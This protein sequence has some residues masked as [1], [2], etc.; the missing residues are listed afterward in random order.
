MLRNITIGVFNK[1]SK[2]KKNKLTQRDNLNNCKNC[3]SYSKGKL[4]ENIINK[5]PLNV[6]KKQNKYITEKFYTT[7]EENKNSKIYTKKI[8]PISKDINSSIEKKHQNMKK[9]NITSNQSYLKD[10][11]KSTNKSKTKYRGYS[12]SKEKSKYESKL[13]SKTIKK[14]KK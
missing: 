4:K 10:E 12:S 3:K 5:T 14:Q 8:S 7:K 6:S 13:I 1:L 2:S 9:N 11:K